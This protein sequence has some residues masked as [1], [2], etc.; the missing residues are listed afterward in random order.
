[1]TAPEKSLI[2]FIDVQGRLAQIVDESE[3][4]IKNM[5][6]LA[7]GA[8][9]VGVRSVL[10]EQRPDKLGPTIPALANA[11]NGIA[12]IAKETFSCCGCDAFKAAVA[13]L[14]PETVYIAG[15]ET[16]ICVYQTARDLLKDGYRVEVVGDAV[17]SRTPQN[18]RLGIERILRDGGAETSVEMALFDWLRTAAHPAFRSV[19]GIVK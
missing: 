10:T 15:I 14:S 1:M 6:S 2:L 12:P 13:S 5:I 7:A 19:P 3:R 8:A 16:H 11:L 18:R 4:V 17:S 9:A